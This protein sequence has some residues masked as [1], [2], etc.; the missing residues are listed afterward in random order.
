[1]ID[2]T[3]D[4]AKSLWPEDAAIV[5]VDSAIISVEADGSSE[6]SVLGSRSFPYTS[7]ANRVHT[8]SIICYCHLSYIKET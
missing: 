2:A 5:S 8:Y 6:D 1:M 7:T 3:Q 4:G